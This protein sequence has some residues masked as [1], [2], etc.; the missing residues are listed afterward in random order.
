MAE[1]VKDAM[2]VCENY[3]PQNSWRFGRKLPVAMGVSRFTK[4]SPYMMILERFLESVL[5]GM[6]LLLAA[7]EC[8][9]DRQS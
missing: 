8:P 4:W 6:L 2:T 1:I 3:T 5:P 9:L 7:G